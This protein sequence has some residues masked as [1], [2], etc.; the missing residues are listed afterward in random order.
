MT[1]DAKLGLVAGMAA[2]LVVAAVYFQ[3]PKAVAAEPRASIVTAL[4]PAE[5]VPA[6]TPNHP[7]K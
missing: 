6:G 4:T 7:W 3:K 2:V 5:I 1:N